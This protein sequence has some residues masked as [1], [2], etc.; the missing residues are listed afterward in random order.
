MK[1]E[2]EYIAITVG[3]GMVGIWK[4]CLTNRVG[5]RVVGD[6]P[7]FSMHSISPLQKTQCRATT[8]R[9]AI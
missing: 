2:L 3:R 9:R 8:P 7:S 6:D 1:L 4:Q 5:T